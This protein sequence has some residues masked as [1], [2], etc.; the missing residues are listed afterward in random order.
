MLGHKPFLPMVVSPAA[1]VQE[2]VSAEVQAFSETRLLQ[3]DQISWSHPDQQ[4]QQVTHSEKYPS[5][6]NM[7][8]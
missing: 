5:I 2:V 1:L 3:E 8:K 7:H 6:N 4:T